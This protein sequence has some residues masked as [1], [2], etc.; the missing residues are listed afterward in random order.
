MKQNKILIITVFLILLLLGLLL[1]GRYSYNS[2]Y[3]RDNRIKITDQAGRTVNVP[4][5]VDRIISLWPE[6]TR[7]IIALGQ[8]EKI[9][10]V[11][12]PEKTDPIFT[13][14]YPKL[15]KLPDLGG[16]GQGVN[17]EE[18]VSLKPDIIFQ[19]A[20]NLNSA[21]DIQN[22]TNIPVVCVRLNPPVLKG[23]FSFDIIN[24]IGKAIHREKKAA[25]LKKYLDNTVLRITKITSEIPDRNRVKGLVLGPN[26]M[27]NGHCD[28]MQSGGVVNVALRKQDIWYHVNPEQ[29]IAWQPDI[30]FV[31]VLHKTT[32][33]TP[34]EI[35][36]SPEWQK[37]K[38]VKE[39]KVHNVIIGYCGWYPSTTVINIM[40][41]AKSAYPE[42]FKDLDIEKQGND[43]FQV[44]YGI[45]NFFTS[46]VKEYDI[47]IP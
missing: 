25:E 35:L 30:V 6:A 41:I 5:K 46:L 33:V 15:K 1:L 2:F 13:K 28:P 39:K 10:G 36:S 37:V 16:A 47:Y 14:I 26:K 12:S 19:D 43:I 42:K 32:G 27:V 8:G 22:K 4:E 21:D 20:T 45:D 23:E 24:L 38:A 44:L 9:V 18:L 11:D 7:I 29:I 34:A 17:I 3:S 40:Q 31:H